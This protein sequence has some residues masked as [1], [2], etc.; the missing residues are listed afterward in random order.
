MSDKKEEEEDDSVKSPRPP[1]KELGE[2]TRVPHNTDA[3]LLASLW[4]PK[5]VT[6]NTN[7]LVLDNVRT[8]IT[9][10][11]AKLNLNDWVAIVV[12]WINFEK[13]VSKARAVFEKEGVP[14]SIAYAINT[15]Y[16]VVIRVAYDKEYQRSMTRQNFKSFTR[17]KRN[18]S[19]FVKS[20]VPGLKES[21][22][23]AKRDEDQIWR[24]DRE[25]EMA[26]AQSEAWFAKQNIERKAR[27][28]KY[29]SS[30][31]FFMGDSSSGRSSGGSSSDDSS[32][33]SSS[34]DSS[35][36]SGSS[37]KSSPRTPEPIITCCLCHVPLNGASITY[38]KCLD[39]EKNNRVVYLCTGCEG[40]PYYSPV[41]GHVD[42][43]VT[44]KIRPETSR[45]I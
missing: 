42:S 17:M 27:K 18:V 31:M 15:L 6:F 7:A 29:A 14:L 12:E 10:I 45:R 25:R 3:Q 35:S 41:A 26:K 20:D 38:F 32:S 13:Q 1:R 22:E 5:S 24:A 34:D 23:R 30:S 11:T 8:S 9:Q 36:G 37:D 16:E 33:G 39:C 2:E 40:G 28:E 4:G 19:A 44:A 43:H 21:L